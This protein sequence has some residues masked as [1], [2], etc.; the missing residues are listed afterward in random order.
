MKNTKLKKLQVLL[1]LVPQSFGYMTTDGVEIE[2]ED[3]AMEMG[4]KVYVITPEGQLPIPDGEYEMEMGAKLKTMGGVIEKME[5]IK[6]EQEIVDIPADNGDVVLVPA[7]EEMATATL[8]DGTK[9]EAEGDFEVGKPL[10]VITEAGE[11][12]PAPMG[13]HTTDS[14]IVVVVDAEGVITGITKPD[15]APEGSLEA[16]EMSIDD[17]V[18]TF[19]SALENLNKKLNEMNDRFTDLDGKFSKFSSL[20]A[21]EKIYDKKGF[22]TA[23]STPSYSNKAEALM[24]LRK[25]HKN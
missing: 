16:S 10:F 1:G 6:P 23:V 25:Q 7:D 13:E 9:V 19:T 15:M 21:G 11:R 12:V 14:G 22:S 5:T 2:I 3:D 4:K 20:P 24:A 18:E 17:V 8:V